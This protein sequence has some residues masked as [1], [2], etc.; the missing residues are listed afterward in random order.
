MKRQMCVLAI[1]I[2]IIVV[3]GENYDNSIS[4]FDD[5]VQQNIN[6]TCLCIGD[7]NCDLN[8]R[9]CRITHSDHA[10]YESWTRY[11]YD[12]TIH[13]TAGC[14]Y[15]DFLITQI[16]CHSNQTNRYIIC[17]TERNNCNDRDAYSNDIRKQFSLLNKRKISNKFPLISILC[18][19]I[20]FISL[21]I[22]L[23]AFLLIRRKRNR[24]KSLAHDSKND[25]STLKRRLL[26]YLCHQSE[27]LSTVIKIDELFD[28]MSEGSDRCGT[29]FLTP[30][31]FAKQITLDK[32][33]G[34]G[35]YGCVYRG[36][37]HD[38]I[39]AV[40]IFSST[41]EPSWVREVYIYETLCLNH[42]NILR[43]IAADNID[44]SNCIERWIAT[45]YHENG[46]VYDYLTTHTIT[47]PIMIK[48]M[49]S[50][51]SGLYHLHRPIDAARGKVSLAHRDL[52][53][54]NILVKKDLSCC[55]ADLGLAVKEKR[56]IR[57]VEE[58]PT[59]ID[60][61]ANHR[62]GTIRYMSPEILNKTLND[63]SFES[64]KAADLYALGLVFWEILRRCRTIS[65]VNDA[66]SYLLPYE[67][68]LPNNPSFEQMHEVVYIRKLRPLP[69]SRWTNHSTFCYIFDRCQELWL[70]DPTCRPSSYLIQKQLREQ[71]QSIEIESLNTYIGSQIEGPNTV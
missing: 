41:D 18:L 24:T 13:V 47:V 8:S 30:I 3:R 11:M 40:K 55:I 4:F 45:E 38:E 60:I 68:T 29:P 67:D 20:G 34:V 65:E 28:E 21:S 10:C 53:T 43:Y 63:Q 12:E 49:F 56:Q 58:K 19:S 39:I 14:M 46:S 7:E 25:E 1:L 62:A 2:F 69:S 33:I 70:D 23:L 15:N 31:H 22:C 52:K 16:L 6:L 37:W 54:K 26:N 17:C 57:A 71:S 61:I 44:I 32:K 48:M 64:Y 9:T 59:V 50:I 5:D 36:K 66:D 51:A 35:G 27:P 42:E